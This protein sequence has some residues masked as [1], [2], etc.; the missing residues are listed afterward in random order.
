[1]KLLKRLLQAGAM[2][3]VLIPAHAEVR[4]SPLVIDLGNNGINLGPA[5]VGVYFDMDANGTRDHLQ[6]VQA[7]GDE[8]FLALDR[9]GNGVV[10]DGAELFGVGTPMILEGRNAPNGFVGLAQYDSRQL[11]GNDDGLITEADAIWPQLRIWLDANAD[12]VSTLDEMRT[13]KSTGLTALETIPKRRKYVDDAGN[14]IPYWAWAQQR[15]RPGRALMVDVF[16][17][18]L[19]KV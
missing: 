1:M 5:G 4:C 7:G 8:G 19:P 18:V 15:A 11:G 3:C 13:L 17:V 6:W 10:D 12:G 9:S 16:F 2:L 14:F